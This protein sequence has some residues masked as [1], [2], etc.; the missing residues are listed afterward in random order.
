MQIMDELTVKINNMLCLT[1]FLE[2][3]NFAKTISIHDVCKSNMN[4]FLYF[5]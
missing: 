4:A 3:L 5:C 2:I 1:V